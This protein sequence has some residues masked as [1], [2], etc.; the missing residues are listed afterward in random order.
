ML[1]PIKNMVIIKRDA[2][3]EVSPGGIHVPESAQ[4]K[5]TR[6]VVMA[7][8]PGIREESEIADA[9]GESI[10]KL[11]EL[12]K[13]DLSKPV[14]EFVTEVERVQE[15][16]RRLAPQLREGDRVLFGKYTGNETK[17]RDRDGVEHECIL[18]Q[19]DQVYGVIES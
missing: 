18:T 8:G 16:L 7:V 9:L 2:K 6:G 19:D 14:A 4:E 13:G 5:V 3:E 17:V 1:R 12:T 10:D 11:R 15:R